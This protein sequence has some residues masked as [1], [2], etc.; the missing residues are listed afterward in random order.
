LEHKCTEAS[1]FSL[2]HTP[3]NQLRNVTLTASTD[4]NIGAKNPNTKGPRMPES[5]DHLLYA[6]RNRDI[7]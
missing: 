4:D 2:T 1:A 6:E 5:T 3:Q 7:F